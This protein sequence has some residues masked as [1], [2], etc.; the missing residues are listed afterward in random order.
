MRVSVIFFIF[1]VLSLIL[2][3]YLHEQVHVSIYEDYNISS[4]VNYISSFPDFQTIPDKP[5]PTESCIEQHNFNEAV[6]YNTLPILFVLIIGLGFII[7][8]IEEKTL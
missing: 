1:G 4:K 3:G 8:A 2:V 7:L 5:C 6:G